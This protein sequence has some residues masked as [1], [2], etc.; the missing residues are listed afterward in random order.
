MRQITFGRMKMFARA[1]PTSSENPMAAEFE[2]LAMPLVNSAYNLARWLLQNDNDAED[3]VQ[4]T[5]LKAFQHFRS[6]QP[7]TNF[8]AWIFRI[9]RN[10]FL[11]SRST[12]ERRMTVELNW[13][14]ELPLLDTDRA[15]PEWLLIQKSDITAIREAIEQLPFY[16]REVIL[17]CDVEDLTYKEIAEVLEIPIGT[18]MSRLARA[19]KVLRDALRPAQMDHYRQFNSALEEAGR[20]TSCAHQKHLYV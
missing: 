7:G 14:E 16:Y 20:Q 6:F 15:S 1:T 10:T 12:L 18:V 13:E 8:R 3:L 17:L 4:E 9:L 2:D 11:T 5:Y 19:R